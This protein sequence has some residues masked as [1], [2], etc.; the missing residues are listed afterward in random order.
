ME[1]KIGQLVYG[2]FQQ[3]R[4]KKMKTGTK[5]VKR[6]DKTVYGMFQQVNVEL[7]KTCSKF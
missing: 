3:T 6:I 2:M 7:R 5:L 4:V 1:K